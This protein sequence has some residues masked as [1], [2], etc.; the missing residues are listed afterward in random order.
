MHLAQSQSR[1]LIRSRCRQTSIDFALI[2]HIPDSETQAACPPLTRDLV[3]RA[4]N[5][6]P[7]SPRT[8]YGMV[9][10]YGAGGVT[11]KGEVAPFWVRSPLPTQDAGIASR[12]RGKGACGNPI[13]PEWRGLNAV[14]LLLDQRMADLRMPLVS[15]PAKFA[16]TRLGCRQPDPACT[17]SARLAGV[18]RIEFGL[19]VELITPVSAAHNSKDRRPNLTRS[20]FYDSGLIAACFALREYHRHYWKPPALAR[21]ESHELRGLLSSGVSRRLRNPKTFSNSLRIKLAIARINEIP[22]TRQNTQIQSAYPPKRRDSQKRLIASLDGRSVPIQI[23]VCIKLDQK[24]NAL[25]RGS[26]RS[27]MIASARSVLVTIERIHSAITLRM[28]Y[29]WQLEPLQQTLICPQRTHQRV[30]PRTRHRNIALCLATAL[31]RC[32]AQP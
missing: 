4:G 6:S 32:L 23:V 20:L 15:K 28:L 7:S 31:G 8:L 2:A 18:L 21:S 30:T 22:I 12:T 10:T 25:G 17:A 16:P 13:G 26:S 24:R 11:G 19:R 29:P 5:L 1:C 27:P 3:E 14:L 9:A